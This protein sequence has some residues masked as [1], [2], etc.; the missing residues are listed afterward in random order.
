MITFLQ[1]ALPREPPR[2]APKPTGVLIG[3]I[4]HHDPVPPGPRDSRNEFPDSLVKN[5]LRA[6]GITGVMLPR[7]WVA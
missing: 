2:L 7:Y 1:F 6:Y 4:G 3:R 5:A